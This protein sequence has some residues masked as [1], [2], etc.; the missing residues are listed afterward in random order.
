MN[1]QVQLAHR[2]VGGGGR[3]C[4][5]EGMSLIAPNWKCQPSFTCSVNLA[6]V[7]DAS[8][9]CVPFHCKCAT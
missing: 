9:V 8:V 4:L 7:I 6:V 3:V 2:G 1:N 5:K